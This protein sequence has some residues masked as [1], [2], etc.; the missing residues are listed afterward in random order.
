M[1][2]ARKQQVLEKLAGWLT[3]NG[4][5]KKRKWVHDHQSTTASIVRALVP[6][7]RNTRGSKSLP[8]PTLG[9]YRAERAAGVSRKLTKGKNWHVTPDAKPL[10]SKVPKR[11]VV[12]YKKQPQPVASL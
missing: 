2:R 7:A 8:P 4:W 12:T 9:Q 5:D 1:T 10:V 11:H 3:P 6:A